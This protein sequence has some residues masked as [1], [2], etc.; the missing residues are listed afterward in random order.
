MYVP[1]NRIFWPL[2]AF[3]KTRGASTFVTANVRLEVAAVGHSLAVEQIET[4]DGY[5][6]AHK[7]TPRL[8]AWLVGAFAAVAVLMAGVGVFGLVAGTVEDRRKDIGIRMAL[9]AERSDVLASIL[10]HG[11]GLALV[12]VALG[13]AGAWASTRLLQTLLF[14]VQPTDG[15]AFACGAG[16]LV[17]AVLLACYV[18]ARR[19]TRVDPIEALRHE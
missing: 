8:E 16:A 1:F 11:L 5:L 10:L 19:A 18:P 6:T 4:I 12:G 15:V 2:A 7:Q 13:L 14:G 17:L 3:V 9:G